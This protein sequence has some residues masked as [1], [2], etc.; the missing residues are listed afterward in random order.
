MIL[1]TIKEQ[2]QLGEIEYLHKINLVCVGSSQAKP[3]KGHNL[4]LLARPGGIL[5]SYPSMS[6]VSVSTGLKLD[7]GHFVINDYNPDKSTIRV[8]LIEAAALELK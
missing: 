5:R 7:S 4:G 2:M 8:E 6:R 3:V 1:F